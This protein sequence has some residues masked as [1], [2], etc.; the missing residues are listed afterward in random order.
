MPASLTLDTTLATNGSDGDT[1]TKTLS[2]R[3][4]TAVLQVAV[5]ESAAVDVTV[6]VRANEQLPWAALGGDATKTLPADT[7][8]D[9]WL[10]D[11]GDVA[12][13]RLTAVNQDTST[14]ASLKAAFS[15]A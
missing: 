4:T 2:V 13:V 9:I 10:F 12:E 14:E 5:A 1:A 3:S 7:D 15:T 8:T 11:V 6:D